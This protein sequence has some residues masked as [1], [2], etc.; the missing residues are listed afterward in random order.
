MSYLRKHHIDPERVAFERR[1]LI[2]GT[3]IVFPVYRGND[4]IYFQKRDVF[5][6]QFYNPNIET[7]PL[8]WT[9]DE[10]DRC[11]LVESFLNACRID[12]WV[13]GCCVFGKF[14]SDEGAEEIAA[15][16]KVVD[17]ILDAG[18]SAAAL[19][20]ARKLRHYGVRFV[21]HKSIMAPQGTDVCELNDIQ[22]RRLLG[23]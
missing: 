9:D 12:K 3:A 14:L 6:K 2:D 17:V 5:T 16:C 11:V 22:C 8:F 7:K 23:V 18:E 10:G 4:M 19:K 20:I 13:T 15:R 1:L 21:A